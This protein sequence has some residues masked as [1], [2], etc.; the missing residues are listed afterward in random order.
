[1]ELLKHLTHKCFQS[2]PTDTEKPKVLSCPEEVTK[3]TTKNPARV[4]WDVPTF[5]DNYDKKPV[6]DGNK[7]PGTKFPY[8]RTKVWYQAVD[9]Y[10]NVATCQ[11]YVI[12][13]RMY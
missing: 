5:K 6:I 11:F 9:S 3:V 10:G 2:F 13:S 8:G 1:M 12:V 4:A 7:V